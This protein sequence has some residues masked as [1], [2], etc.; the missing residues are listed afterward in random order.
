V[1]RSPVRRKRDPYSIGFP[2]TNISQG[3]LSE[4]TGLELTLT[5]HG[6][7]KAQITAEITEEIPM[8]GDI[9]RTV[10]VEQSSVSYPDSEKSGVV[11]DMV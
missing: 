9:Y 11:R 5:K 6:L 4:D 7:V 3:Y 1:A 10:D 8:A 2:T